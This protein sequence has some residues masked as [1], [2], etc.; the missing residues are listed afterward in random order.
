[1]DAKVI[2]EIGYLL[3]IYGREFGLFEEI[4]ANS[5]SLI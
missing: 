1:V 4:Y 3:E 5:A 2:I